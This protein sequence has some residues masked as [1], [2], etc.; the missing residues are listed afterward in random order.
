MPQLPIRELLPEEQAQ[1]YVACSGGT[2]PRPQS[3]SGMQMLLPQVQVAA[4]QA[5]GQQPAAAAPQVTEAESS[6]EQAAEPGQQQ[7]QRQQGS[8]STVVAERA[9]SSG[10]AA[11]AVLLVGDAVHC[12]PPDLGQGVNSALE[13]VLV[14]NSVLDEC[15]DDLHRA[16]PLFEERRM[17]DVKALITLMQWGAPY[18]YNQDPLARSLWTMNFV[19]RLG[20]SKVFPFVAPPAFMMVQDGNMSYSTMLARAETTTRLLQG[21]LGFLVIMTAVFLAT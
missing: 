16:L 19:I 11:Q 20:L 17:P 4:A 14:L 1:K 10:A 3:C 7:R 5:L 15:G 12:F 18:Q 2:F 6:S 9:V 21:T 8:A 13:D